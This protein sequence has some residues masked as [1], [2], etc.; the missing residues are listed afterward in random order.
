[1]TAHLIVGIIAVKATPFFPFLIST[2][3]TFSAV[4][5]SEG[6]KPVTRIAC[7]KFKPDT[8]PEQKGDRTRAFL[9]LYAQHEDF[10]SSMPEG[11]KPLNTP[12]DLTNVKRESGW[13]TG[14]VVT[15]KVSCRNDVRT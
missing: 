10:I 13:D 11:G 1:M 14:F 6:G 15:F 4:T 7:F 8:S 2:R 5:M 9:G 12:L 3:G